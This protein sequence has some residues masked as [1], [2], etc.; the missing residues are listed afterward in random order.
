VTRVVAIAAL[1]AGLTGLSTSAANART[2]HFP[3]TVTVSGNGHVRG[4]GDGGSIDCPG[5]CI[6]HIREGT[7]IVLH[8]DPDPG[9]VFTG[10]GGACAGA[11]DTSCGIYINGDTTVTAGFGVAP[12]PPPPRFTLTV[13]KAG[14][15]TGFVGATG[16]DCGTT[17][18]ASFDQGLSV[19]LVAVADDGSEFTG[20]TGGGCS[21]TGQCVVTL[22]A[23]TGVTARF[24][25]VDRAPPIVSTLHTAARRGATALLRYRIFDDSGMSRVSVLVIDGKRRLASIA[26]P[27]GPVAYR[28]IYSVPWK[29]PVKE[30][31]GNKTFCV[32][33][34]DAAGNVGKRSCSLVTV[35]VK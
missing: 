23:D 22:S 20:W 33:G 14:T 35:T 4:I 26:V 21:G 1:V 18:A 5:V 11:N 6:A 30:K 17:C 2:L 24:D 15:G 16:I 8:A 12:P 9:N 27:L 28:R 10:W 29:V 19:S 3:V 32:T 34:T 13:T 25:H 7:G 31:P